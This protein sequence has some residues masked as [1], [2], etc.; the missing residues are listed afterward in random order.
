MRTAKQ[1]ADNIRFAKNNPAGTLAY[2][3]HAAAVGDR[4]SRIFI[5]FNGSAAVKEI[6]LP[7]G[8]W[9]T[10]VDNNGPSRLRKSRTG[11]MKLNAYSATILYQ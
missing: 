9:A 3:I 10:V 7:A 5:A 8:S 1:I 2:T 11:N 6:Q 4:W